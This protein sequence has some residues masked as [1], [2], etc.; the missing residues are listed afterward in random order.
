MDIKF[1]IRV[2]AFGGTLAASGTW[3]PGDPG[4]TFG[5]PERCYPPDPAE[6]TDLTRCVLTLP[7][8]PGTTQTSVIDLLAIPDEL[9]ADDFSERIDT[10]LLSALEN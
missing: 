8:R 1:D 3:W 7:P 5:P 9:L 4:N 2:A 10:V 6:I